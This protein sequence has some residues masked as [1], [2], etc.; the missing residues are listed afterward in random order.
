MGLRAYTGVGSRDTPQEILVVM[1]RVAERLAKEGWVL[2][3]G[4]A[5]GADTAFWEGHFAIH[6]HDPAFSEIYLP[7]ANFNHFDSP[8]GIVGPWLDNW[9]EATR[10]AMDVV[11]H[12]DN[13]KEWQKPFHIR[14][15]YQVLGLDLQTPSKRVIFWAPPAHR[16]YRGVVLGGTNTA[17]QV[18]KRFNVGT[19]NMYFAG[20]LNQIKQFLNPIEKKSV[21]QPEV[22]IPRK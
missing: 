3:S 2:R 15:V 13:L 6:G 12:W 21:E 8:C 16:I 5:P 17:L 4:A 22:Q 11:A 14:N 19:L 1:R 7:K 10:I 18:A 20:D 9:D